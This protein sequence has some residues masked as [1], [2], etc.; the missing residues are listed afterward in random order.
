M[1]PPEGPNVTTGMPSETA[2]KFESQTEASY[3]ARKVLA[4]DGVK[5]LLQ[6]F[7][8]RMILLHRER[9]HVGRI[10]SA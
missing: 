5:L 3:R 2:K 6:N 7:D 8:E 9:L 4:R 10:F 1:L